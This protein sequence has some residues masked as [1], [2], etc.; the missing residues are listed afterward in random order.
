M[1]LVASLLH[2]DAFTT[3]RSP[4]A[5]HNDGPSLTPPW[6]GSCW[7]F[8]VHWAP[9]HHS[10]QCNTPTCCISCDLCADS[11]SKDQSCFTFMLPDKFPILKIP[12]EGV[13]RFFYIGVIEDYSRLGCNV[14]C[15]PT[16]RRNLS[17]WCSRV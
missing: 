3:R 13:W 7:W 5:S 12:L 8:Q 1:T 14:R 2:R 11:A 10:S 4:V 16:F 17:S 15:F 6:C 9:A